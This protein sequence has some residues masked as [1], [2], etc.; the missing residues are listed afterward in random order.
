MAS[1][2]ETAQTECMSSLHALYVR[3]CGAD[4][5]VVQNPQGVT[6]SHLSR[7]VLERLA[8]EGESPVG[9]KI[10]ISCD[11]VPKYYGTREIL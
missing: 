5:R 6:K 4:P 2:R 3:G 7:T 10:A 11:L 1:E 9:E 8:T